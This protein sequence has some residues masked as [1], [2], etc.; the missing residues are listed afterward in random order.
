M[1][2]LDLLSNFF[3]EKL[4]FTPPDFEIESYIV[5]ISSIA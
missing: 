3:K 1:K 5:F 4:S 2:R